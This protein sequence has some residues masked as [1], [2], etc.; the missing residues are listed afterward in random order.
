M[1]F[2]AT[3]AGDSST[4]A[5]AS[6]NSVLVS[7]LLTFQVTVDDPLDLNVTNIFNTAEMTS[8]QQ[9]DPNKDTV[10]DPVDTGAAIGNSVW[11]DA[12]GDGIQ[13]V[14]EDGLANVVVELRDGVCTPAVDC[15]TT[16][17]DANGNYLFAYLVPGTYTV[18]VLSGV[19]TG[20]VESPGNSSGVSDPITI[21]G[22]EQVL[23]AD[24][25]YTARAASAAP[26]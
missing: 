21:S 7:P 15:P 14:G 16:T 19:P 2:G 25:G 10:V 11:L 18:A 24:F 13:D 20:L 17:T 26:E 23:D 1:T 5:A 3:A 9:P 12:D 22:S 4:F 8:D 6:S